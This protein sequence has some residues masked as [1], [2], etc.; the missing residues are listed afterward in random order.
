MPVYTCW[1]LWFE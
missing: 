1:W